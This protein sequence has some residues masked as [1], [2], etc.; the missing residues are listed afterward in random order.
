[1]F[2]VSVDLTVCVLGVPDPDATDCFFG[3]GGGFQIMKVKNTVCVYFS[4]F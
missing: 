3:G 2:V 1:M 4:A